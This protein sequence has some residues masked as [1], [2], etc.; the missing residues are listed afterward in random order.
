MSF[1]LL[2]AVFLLKNKGQLHTGAVDP[3]LHAGVIAT[4]NK[5]EEAEMSDSSERADHARCDKHERKKTHPARRFAGRVLAG[6]IS[7]LL[8]DLVHKAITWIDS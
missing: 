2:S 3:F 8:V 1:L 6:V 5:R 7:K 4:D